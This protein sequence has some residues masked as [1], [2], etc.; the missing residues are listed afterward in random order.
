MTTEPPREVEVEPVALPARMLAEPP[1]DP[2]PTPSM[3]SPDLPSEEDPES[4]STLP[5]EE[6]E[7]P[8]D[9]D[10][11]PEEPEEEED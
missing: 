2:A 4:T 7:E 9:S 5:L 6:V 10:A 3:I 8:E 11:L 1:A